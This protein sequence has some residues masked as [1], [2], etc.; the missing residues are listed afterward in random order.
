M[1]FRLRHMLAAS[2]LVASCTPNP[3]NSTG[4]R[5]DGSVKPAD[6]GNILDAVPAFGR[7]ISSSRIEIGAEVSGVVDKVLVKVGDTVSKGD[8]LASIRNPTLSA[9]L[10]LAKAGLE[11]SVA[12]KKTAEI[13]LDGAKAQFTRLG[14]TAVAEGIVSA[15]EYDRQSFEVQRLSAELD[16][17]KASVAQARLIIEEAQLE[18]Q[19]TSL[20]APAN[21][22]VEAILVEP[23]QTVN[24]ST[25]APTLIVLSSDS[26]KI[27][28]RSDVAETDIS[29]IHPDMQIQV[30][31][32]AYP[33]TV[34]KGYNIKIGDVGTRK[35]KFVSYPVEFELDPGTHAVFSEMSASIE[36]VNSS[37]N[38]VLRIPKS[39]LYYQP[40]DYMPNIPDRLKK[41]VD[42]E[43]SLASERELKAAYTGVE[44]G[45]YAA[46][47]ERRVFTCIS[48]KP[49]S[50]GVRIGAEDE[51]FVEVVS[52]DVKKGDTVISLANS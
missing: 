31:L 46:R 3:G 27:I 35:G 14:G 43:A 33:A 49:Q 13:A 18:L 48:G 23:G 37:A 40:K 4:Q 44:L 28:V 21:G 38:R 50:V 19:K 5:C 29:R 22:R 6:I 17:A 42:A 30:T 20:L 1:F 8:L 9:R 41:A 36:F 10:E 16:T 26:E 32:Q 2:L 52:G 12:R 47:N 39:A 34:F 11:A 7:V 15:S 45:L 24:A 25:T 51:D